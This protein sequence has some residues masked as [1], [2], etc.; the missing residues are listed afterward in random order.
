MS[1]RTPEDREFCHVLWIIM[2]L[3]IAVSLLDVVIMMLVVDYL[4]IDY[5]ATAGAIM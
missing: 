4:V 1:K 5:F 3:K 2:H